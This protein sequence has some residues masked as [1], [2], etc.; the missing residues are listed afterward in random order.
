MMGDAVPALRALKAESPG[1]RLVLGLRD[2]FDT[3]EQA[4]AEWTSAGAQQL[5]ESVYD[6][7]LVYGIRAVC[8]V[9]ATYG[10]SVNVRAKVRYVGYL[11]RAAHSPARR[12][13]LPLVLVTVGGGGDGYELMTQ[14]LADLRRAYPEGRPSF[15]SLL[16]TGPF[17]PKSEATA[18]RQMA[19]AVGGR[20]RVSVKAFVPALTRTIAQADV[21]V[22]MAGYNTTCEI[23]TFGR[24]AILVP[25]VR[26]R[27][28]QLI[29]ARA[30]ARRGLVR[31]LHPDEMV[32]GKLLAEVQDTLASPARP[33]RPVD[34]DGLPNAAHELEL[35]LHSSERPR[36]ATSAVRS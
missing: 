22:A 21:V 28:E 26:P 14:Y 13:R 36:A 3:P 5:M 4:V 33:H 35:L 30:L 10:M 6:L 23:L 29:R 16:V 20:G 27:Q 15:R 25:R 24:P 34:L 12:G 32:P 7:I 31:M 1:T 8:D 17:M 11:G 2:I 18:L 9:G 19:R